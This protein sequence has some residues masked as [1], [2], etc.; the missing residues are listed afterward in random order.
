MCLI[1][2]RFQ[3]PS[4]FDSN[5]KFRAAY[6]YSFTRYFYWPEEKQR[7]NFVI[8]VIGKNDNLISEL[9]KLA[10]QKKVGNQGIE[11]KNSS[12]YDPSVV[13]H[14]IYFTPSQDGESVNEA[15]EKNKNKGTLVVSETNSFNGGASINFLIV[16]NKLKFDYSKTAAVKAGLKTSEGFKTLVNK[17]ID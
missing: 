1:S 4:N 11:I 7:D 12:A 2:F 3:Q 6:L 14:I 16:D 10:A 8:Y 17:T 5:S 13:S 15:A 9:K